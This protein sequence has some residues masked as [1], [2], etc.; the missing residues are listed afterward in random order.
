MQR[1]KDYIHQH[2]TALFD[3]LVMFISFTLGFLFPSLS[4]FIKSTVFYNLM[5]IAL[6]LYISGALLKHRPLSYRILIKGSDFRPVSYVLF[7]VIGHWIIMFV[8]L[9]LAE[10]ALMGMLGIGYQSHSS[11][12]LFMLSAAFLAGF[13]TWLVYRNKSKQAKPV[14]ISQTLLFRQELIADILLIAGV[15]IISFIFWEKGVMEMLSRV[16]AGSIGE[17][18]FL[19]IF[20]ALMFLFFY[21]P[22]RYLFFVEEKDRSANRNRLFLI[23]GFLLLK[24]L[25]EMLHI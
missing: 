16:S 9:I 25:F 6:L 13:I 24:A 19:F 1:A 21:L 4:D 23:F 7:L 17:I 5:L 8:L 2:R 11:S 3:W 22:L 18:W 15:S 14:L 12:N 20:L 10:P